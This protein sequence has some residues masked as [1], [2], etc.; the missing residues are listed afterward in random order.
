LIEAQLDGL[1]HNSFSGF[2]LVISLSL[3]PLPLGVFALNAVSGVEKAAG[4]S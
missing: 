3:A 2:F 4:T 1:V